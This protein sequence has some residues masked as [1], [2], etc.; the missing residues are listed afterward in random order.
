MFHKLITLT[1][2]RFQLSDQGYS[3]TT[4]AEEKD[5]SQAHD[6]TDHDMEEHDH[7]DMD[8]ENLIEQDWKGARLSA[9]LLRRQKRRQR[10]RAN[11]KIGRAIRRFVQRRGHRQAT[12]YQCLLEQAQRSIVGYLDY[13]FGPMNLPNDDYLNNTI[14][15][16]LYKSARVSSIL[17]F[18]GIQKLLAPL[19][20]LEP[21]LQLAIVVD[22][23]RWSQTL[24]C[25]P[26]C[27]PNGEVVYF[28]RVKPQQTFAPMAS[29]NVAPAMVMPAYWICVCSNCG[30]PCDTRFN[31]CACCGFIFS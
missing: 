16:P 28:I 3:T 29:P 11:A 2:T 18:E 6:S 31:Y 19:A 20:P 26:I 24:R 22:S 15:E 7:E 14:L 25:G 30:Q 13:L 10:Q 23:L 27:Y 4:E 8:L 12:Y 1:H 21:D 17:H 9:P 5:D